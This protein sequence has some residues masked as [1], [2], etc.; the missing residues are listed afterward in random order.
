[1]PEPTPYKEVPPVETAEVLMLFSVGRMVLGLAIAVFGWIFAQAPAT[2]PAT[3]IP[4]QDVWQAVAAGQDPHG[5]VLVSGRVAALPGAEPLR[6]PLS[7]QPALAYHAAVTYV[8]RPLVT[9]GKTR[10]RKPYVLSNHLD[11]QRQVPFVVKAGQADVVVEQVPLWYLPTPAA[12]RHD[13]QPEAPG[14]ARAMPGFRD[15]VSLVHDGAFET[16]E[17]TL[18]PGD[19]VTLIGV[20]RDGG[21]RRALVAPVGKQLIGYMRGQTAIASRLSAA[22]EGARNGRLMA[23][24]ALGFGLLLL[25]PWELPGWLRRRR[26]ARSF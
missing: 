2:M 10:V 13:R 21:G 3:V 6:S 15:R 8:Q 11:V 19:E 14:W 22:G 20:L 5:R 18:R 24:F 26:A 1:M 25:V 12:V 7:A 4:W 9:Q 23:L 17:R 16:E